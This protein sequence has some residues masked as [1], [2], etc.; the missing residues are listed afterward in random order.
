MN[1]MTRR[2]TAALI[3]RG[4]AHVQPAMTLHRL[5]LSGL[6]ALGMTAATV[7]TATA[8]PFTGASAGSAVGQAYAL[9][10]RIR[11][12][13]RWT[14][15]TPPPATYCS[16]MRAGEAIMVELARLAN[17]A[18]RYHQPG[19]ALELQ[20]AGDRLGDELDEEEAINDQAGIPYNGY[21][22]LVVQSSY[23]S[24]AVVLALIERR[25]PLCRRKA[26]AARA[27]FDA[28]RALM[29][30]CLRVAGP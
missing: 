6:V 1:A 8:Q 20:R 2:R 18:I 27:S 5:L 23:P 22:C 19:L 21:P 13:H 9:A 3:R 28:R 25:V 4:Q 29:Y 30:Q 10:A 11:G 17:R 26:D 12:F 16:T 24:R 15:S 14:G 7:A